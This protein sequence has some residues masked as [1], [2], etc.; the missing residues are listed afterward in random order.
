MMVLHSQWQLAL[1]LADKLQPGGLVSW[2]DWE[3]LGMV[4]AAE[5]IDRLRLRDLDVEA[6]TEGLMVMR[7]DPLSRV[8]L[9]LD[10]AG[11]Q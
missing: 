9:A 3:F 11:G 1:S 8:T 10:T 6:C 4:A 5:M 7:S 2:A